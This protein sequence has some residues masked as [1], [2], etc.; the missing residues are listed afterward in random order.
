M[1]KTY[2]DTFFDQGFITNIKIFNNDYVQNAC[3]DYINFINKNTNRQQ[4]VEAKTKTHLFFPW[5]N[6]IIFEKRILDIVQN[7]IGENI[8]CWNSLIFHKK[9][10]TSNFVSMHQDQNYWNIEMNKGLTVSLALTDSNV[11]N[12][13][14]RILPYSHKK[15]YEHIDLN[16]KSNML[17]RGQTIDFKNDKVSSQIQN[18]ELE[19]GECCI[20]HGNIAHG[21]LKN[22]SDSHRVLYA[23]RFL[24]PDN[25]INTSL[26]YNYATLVRGENNL[27][28][29]LN[30]PT[31]KNSEI[32]DLRKLHKEI[33]ISQF[34]KYL[35]LKIK[36]NFL[37]NFFMI[38]FKMDFLRRFLYFYLKKS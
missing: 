35:K 18:I 14:L 2:R 32:S 36:I 23:M 12:G 1:N 6:K 8:V 26:Y 28:N 16:D 19:K 17:A 7:I 22:N 21:S 13:C 9:P 34:S 3:D 27:N 20:F 37:V 24:T 33:I 4:T 25:K 5:A 38:F 31:L 11:E 10:K 15:S 30:E 29:F